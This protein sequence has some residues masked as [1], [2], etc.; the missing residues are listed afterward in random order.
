MLHS[1][2]KSINQGLPSLAIFEKK[3]DENKKNEKLSLFLF[4]YGLSLILHTW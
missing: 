4:V 1:H 3:K 2:R